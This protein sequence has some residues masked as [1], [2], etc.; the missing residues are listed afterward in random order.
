MRHNCCAFR[1]PLFRILAARVCFEVE[2]VPDHVVSDD[3][4]VPVPAGGRACPVTIT[5]VAVRGP[6]GTRKTARTL[7][8]TGV[9]SADVI[10]G[11]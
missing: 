10:A 9:I 4:L 3:E 5:E 6:W 11:A 1:I 7:R 8:S 2:I